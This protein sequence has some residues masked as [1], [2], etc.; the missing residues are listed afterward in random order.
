MEF[1]NLLFVV[2]FIVF[3]NNLSCNVV[4]QVD[5]NW[6]VL[7]N[8]SLI[9]EYMY[10]FYWLSAAS[11]YLSTSIFLLSSS[12]DGH[13]WL[14]NEIWASEFVEPRQS[15]DSSYS[16]SPPSAWHSF[17]HLPVSEER[18]SLRD[19]TPPQHILPSQTP[20]AHHLTLTSPRGR[21]QQPPWCCHRDKE[22]NC[23]CLDVN[24]W[25]CRLILHAK[26]EETCRRTHM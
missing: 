11:V 25:V 3:S 13:V 9:L 26:Q 18:T 15:I 16:N 2:L 24:M 14:V 19:R 8:L 12:G 4:I 23:E 7:T 22:T 17:C 6:F 5:V 21:E 20:P 1:V 10:F